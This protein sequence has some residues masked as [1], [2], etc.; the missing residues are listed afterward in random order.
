MN[1]TSHSHQLLPGTIIKD[2]SPE[3]VRIISTTSARV[4][5]DTDTPLTIAIWSR[6]WKKK[7]DKEQV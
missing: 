6:H 7:N 5:P 4:L 1:D 2:M 3:A